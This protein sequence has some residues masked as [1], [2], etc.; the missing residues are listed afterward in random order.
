MLQCSYTVNMSLL[1]FEWDPKK[2]ASNQ[3]K[4]GVSFDEAETAFLDDEA[5]L[6]PDTEHSSD[7]DRFLILG[8]SYQLRILIVCHCYRESDDVIRIISARKAN[9]SEQ[10]QYQ[11]GRTT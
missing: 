2:A 10:M 1:R 8:F 5:V 4:H 3:R 6:V 9:K 7:E 11:R